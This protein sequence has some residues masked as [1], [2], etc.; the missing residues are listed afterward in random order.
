MCKI[1]WFIFFVF[2][3]RWYFWKKAKN[4]II[5]PPPSSST[6]TSYN[7]NTSTSTYS[8]DR[9]KML[10]DVFVK[11]YSQNIGNS[12]SKFLLFKNKRFIRST[13]FLRQMLQKLL[14]FWEYE[15]PRKFYFFLFR[16]WKKPLLITSPTVQTFRILLYRKP[17]QKGNWR[18]VFAY[19]S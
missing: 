3:L 1:F 18:E 19:L 8:S 12:S 17:F 5:H 6:T 13:L 10:L 15:K 11:H 7:N 16:L 4:V 2:I 14:L 9:K